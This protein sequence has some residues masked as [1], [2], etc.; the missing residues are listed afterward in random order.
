MNG[1]RISRRDLLSL[2]MG[3]TGESSQ[4]IGAL[5]S[6]FNTEM[7]FIEIMKMGKDPATMSR[8]DM[9]RAV[10]KELYKK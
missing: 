2:R 1:N 6:D 4:K 7:L 5:A 9:L 3:R 8:D 10:Y